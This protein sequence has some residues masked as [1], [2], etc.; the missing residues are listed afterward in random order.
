MGI[1]PDM[2]NCG[3][4][5]RQEYRERFPRHRLQR[6]PL[7][8]DPCMHH[9]TCVTHVPWCMSGILTPGGGENVPGIPGAC[10]TR[11][12]TYLARGPWSRTM[13]TVSNFLWIPVPCGHKWYH[14]LNEVGYNFICR[15]E[16]SIGN[17]GRNFLDEHIWLAVF[18][19]DVEYRNNFRRQMLSTCRNI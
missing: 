17:V 9:G 16:D 11:N 6:K 3:L 19:K 1:L 4:R 7:V 5:V 13:C 8:S 15:S 2:E 18:D 10:T 12:F 14:N